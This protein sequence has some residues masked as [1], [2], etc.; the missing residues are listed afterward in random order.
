MMGKGCGDGGGDRWTGKGHGDEGGV[1][2]PRGG[3][4]KKGGVRVTNTGVKEVTLGCLE[5][6]EEP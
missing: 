1:R 5:R 4:G 3:G 2:V 6:T